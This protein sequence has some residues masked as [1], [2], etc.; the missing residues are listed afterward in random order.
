MKIE[1]MEQGS[2]AWLQV[3]LG[4]V[5][6][7]RVCDVIAKTRTGWGAGRA[8]YQAELIV[9][10]LT[11][12]PVEKF[13]NAAMQWGTQTEPDARAAYEFRFDCDVEQVGFV[14]HPRIAMSG[15]S[16]DG[17]VGAEG[18]LEIKCPNC[19][20][21]LDTLLGRSV[22]AKYLTQMQWQMACTGRAWCDFVSFDPRMPA[23]MQIFVARVARD[24]KLISE[25]EQ[26]V[27]DFLAELDAEI[28]ELDR[29]YGTKAAA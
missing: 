18:L 19:A 24:D 25:L 2:D 8:N 27:A 21:H 10:R 20:T 7:S 13:S 29:V 5:T 23:H 3:R 22:P 26:M 9:E 12:Q 14:H 4:R 11:G 17:L 16:P 1:L 15:A 6:A 28:G